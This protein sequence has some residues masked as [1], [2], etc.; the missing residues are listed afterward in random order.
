MSAGTKRRRASEGVTHGKVQKRFKEIRFNW[1]EDAPI[2][3]RSCLQKYFNWSEA[4]SDT[5]WREFW[6]AHKGSVDWAHKVDAA[7]ETCDSLTMQQI[8]AHP[9][10]RNTNPE[11]NQRWHRELGVELPPPPPT[12]P[13]DHIVELPALLL[14]RMWE[15]APTG[16]SFVRDYITVVSGLQA[17]LTTKPPGAEKPGITLPD[18]AKLLTATFGHT[19]RAQCQ[20]KGC[21]CF[22]SAFRCWLLS[23]KAYQPGA[24]NELLVV[25]Q[26]HSLARGF[27]SVHEF[28]PMTRTTETWLHRNGVQPTAPCALCGA[29][30]PLTL[31]GDLEICHAKASAEGGSDEISNLLL[32]HSKCNRDQGTEPIEVYRKRIGSSA[33]DGCVFPLEGLEE[34]RRTLTCK[35]RLNQQRDPF[36]HPVLAKFA[37]PPVLDE[38]GTP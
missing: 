17:I 27:R 3:I 16:V 24:T 1:Q 33:V 25:C 28:K 2:P 23:T 7:N 32:G 18:R 35:H 20:F 36:A 26:I 34:L 30:D 37:F 31:W 6:D 9:K 15:E 22:V 8:L 19:L 10:I 5:R 38:Q 29:G 13:A 4:F 12:M 21:Q 14:Q 11:H